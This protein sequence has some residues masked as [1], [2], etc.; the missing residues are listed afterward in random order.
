MLT[1]EIYN[2]L[3]EAA[4]AGFTKDGDQYVPVKDAALKKTLGE[5]DAKYKETEKRLAEYDQRKAAEIEEARNKAL[6]EA[7]TK[8]DVKAIEERYQQ[9]MADLEK[10]TAERVRNEVT[11]ELSQKQADTKASGIADAIGATLGVDE[12]AGEVIAELIR[13]RV[14]VDAETGKEYFT[15]AAGS[16]LSIGKAE[17][18]EMIKKESRFKHLVKAPIATNGAG[19]ANGSGSGSASSGAGTMS[20]NRQQREAAIAKRF[21]IPVN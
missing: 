5:L 8:G 20:G 21:N 13:S 2:S 15:D 6:E 11:K 14:K 10:R 9:Q 3:P 18:E 1:E 4:K 17:F 12:D 19:G 16:A 7:R